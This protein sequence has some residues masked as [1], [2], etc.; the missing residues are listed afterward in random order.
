M[1]VVQEI[2]LDELYRLIYDSFGNNHSTIG[3][4]LW[5][6]E[7]SDF[8]QYFLCRFASVHKPF[9]KFKQKIELDQFY[10]LIYNSFGN[11]HSV[12]GQKLWKP[13]NRGF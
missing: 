12:I 11:N 2:Q 9:L 1:R 8:Q 4:N 6:P 3:Q 13:E 10:R 5:K 7:N